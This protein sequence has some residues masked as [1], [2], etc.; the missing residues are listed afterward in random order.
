MYLDL[1]S[2]LQT[3]TRAKFENDGSIVIS[4]SQDVTEHLKA[5]K[6]LSAEGFGN[7]KDGKLAASIPKVIVE[8][9]CNDNGITF[10]E[11]M[12]NKEHIKRIL[13]DKSLEHFRIWKGRV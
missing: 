4:R 2:S 12:Q 10:Q 3:A 9:Y 8:K 13:N 6:E 11:F 7:G 5:T 1:T